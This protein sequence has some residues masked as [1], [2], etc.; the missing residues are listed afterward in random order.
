[1]ADNTGM[2]CDEERITKLIKKVSEDEFK[3]Q[4]QNLAKIISG[5]FEITM[6]EIRSL[7]KWSEWVKEEYGIHAERLERK[8]K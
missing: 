7:K 2:L 6:Q 3:K 1:M 5:N 8:S 4:E